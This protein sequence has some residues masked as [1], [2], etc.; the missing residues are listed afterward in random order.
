MRNSMQKGFTLIELMIVIAIIGV[1]A[2]VAIPA[3]QDYISKSQVTAGLAEIAPTK[4]QVELALNAGSITA[5]VTA[6]TNA[7]L[8]PYGLT[9]GTSAR[10]TYKIAITAATGVSTV[11]CTLKGSGSIA[12]KLIHLKR[13]ADTNSTTGTWSCTT[14]ANS[15]FTPVGCTAGATLTAI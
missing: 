15:K 5:D 4:T 2:A 14:D 7:E 9:S 12:G 10:C 8:L 3:Y 11:Q 6:A 13:S 1:L